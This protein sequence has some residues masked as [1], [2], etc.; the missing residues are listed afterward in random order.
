MAKI[1]YIQK[2]YAPEIVDK[3]KMEMEMVAFC[4]IVCRNSLLL[5]WRFMCNGN[6]ADMF[7]GVCLC[8]RGN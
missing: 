5:L 6:D 7:D 4:F 1:V 8:A 3:P 2:L